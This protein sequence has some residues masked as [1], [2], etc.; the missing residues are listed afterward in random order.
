MAHPS[1]YLAVR[2]PGDRL[3]RGR[4]THALAVVDEV[5]LVSSLR[6][7]RLGPARWGDFASPARNPRR[8]GR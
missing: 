4:R 6:F 7:A 2:R 8:L 5:A 3:D 1:R